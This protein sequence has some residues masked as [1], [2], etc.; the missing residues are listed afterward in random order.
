L[1]NRREKHGRIIQTSKKV[2][3]STFPT[4]RG[5]G[6]DQKKKKLAKQGEYLPPE[7]VVEETS[8]VEQGNKRDYGQR[9]PCIMDRGAAKNCRRSEREPGAFQKQL[10]AF[11][12]CVVNGGG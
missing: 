1:E 2:K 9:T 10:N 8:K 4:S 5:K 6:M 11:P 3:A 12:H 7:R